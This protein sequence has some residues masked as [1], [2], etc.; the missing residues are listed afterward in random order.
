[1][2]NAEG[3]VYVAA[4]KCVSLHGQVSPHGLLSNVIIHKKLS[5]VWI[6]AHAGRGRIGPRLSMRYLN[7]EMPIH[8]SH[9]VYTI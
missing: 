5:N 1:M 3:L 9:A 2:E 8:T 7:F 4:S 6:Q